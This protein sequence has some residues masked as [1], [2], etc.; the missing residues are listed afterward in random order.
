MIRVLYC[1]PEG[2]LQTDVPLENV[3]ALLQTAGG[4]VWVDILAEPPSVSE[5]L[6]RDIFRF[7]PLAIDDALRWSHVPRVDDWKEYLYLVLHAVVFQDQ[8]GPHVETPELDV[9]LGKNYL[10]THQDR[11]VPAVEAVWTR[12]GRDERLLKNGPDRLLYELADSLVTDYMPVIEQMDDA[13][14]HIENEI[15]DRPTSS[16]LEFLFDLKRAVIYL[17]RA[18]APQREVFNRLARDE[19]EVITPKNRVY[20]RDV[21]DHLVRLHETSESL[22]DLVAGAVDTYLSVVNNRLS[23]VMK[24]L[25]IITTLF[26]PISFVASFFGMN[27]FQ[28][29]APLHLWTGI[30]SLLVTLA[31][32][33][34]VP[35]SMYLWVR[36]RGWM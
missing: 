14:D 24:T 33:T 30:T 16:T 9:F 19:F 11:P 26:M 32:M 27:F 18:L 20:F 15:F 6:L 3:P 2:Q 25:T 31:I 23:D 12:F 5:P 28:P 1:D 36:R 10:V 35:V 7:H 22:R 17:R 29:T 13:I 4:L 8:D 34:L 21:Y